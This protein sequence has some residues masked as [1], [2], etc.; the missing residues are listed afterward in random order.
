MSSKFVQAT[1]WRLAAFIACVIFAHAV[2]A[3]SQNA[4]ALQAKA[5]TPNIVMLLS[6]DLGWKDIGCYDGPVR[7]P[8]LDRL[9][10]GGMRF[11]DFYSGAAVC[12]PSRAVMLTGRTNVR[13]SIYSW[14]N[15]HDQRSHL[16][17]SEVTLAELLKSA[18]Y[19][20]GHFGKWHL[21]M[22]SRNFPN[23]P[24]PSDHG[25]DYWFAT[26]NNAQPSHRNP[27]NFVRNG[28]NVGPQEGYSC[29]L[30]VDEA[31]DWLD[32]QA[33]VDKPFFL[34]VW[35]HEPHAPLAA[36]AD[37]VE[38]YGDRMDP[39]A[40]YS[41][42]IAN[43]DQ[44]IKRLIAKLHEID[45]PENTLI[46][47]ASDNGSYRSDR[48]G[49]LRA[50]KGSNYEGGIR[51]PG[52]FYWPKHISP[53]VVSR[54]PAGL[55]DIVPTVC[56]IAGIRSPAAHLDGSDLSKLLTGTS[57]RVSREQPLFWCL[58]LSGPAIAMRDGRYSMV[59]F[60]NAAVPK[61]Q[62]GIRNIKKQIEETLKAKGIYEKETRGSTFAKQLFEGFSDRDAERLRGKF[63]RLNQ[64]HESWIPSLKNSNFIRF[65]LY[66][67]VA[68]PSQTRELSSQQPQVH[69]RL[70]AELTRIAK[71]VFN[72]AFDWS[73]DAPAPKQQS[74]SSGTRVHRLKETYRSPFDAFL[75]INR[76]PST[77]EQD[78]THDDLA[79]RILG[80]LANQE[81]RV[82]VKLPPGMNHQAYEGFK[83]ALE[84]GEERHAGNCFTC[85]HL[86][87]F[88][89]PKK[90]AIPSLRHY[91]RS[92][93]ELSATL[94]HEAH[95]NIRLDA[96]DISHLHAL[97]Q[98]LD[99]VSDKK[100][101][102][103]ILKSKV[104]DTSGAPK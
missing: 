102:E 60:R 24:T 72:E 101:R 66:D 75:Y 37:S 62:E 86:P 1:L 92:N 3:Q 5:A 32:A 90:K 78:E 65:E 49:Y 23:K 67:L 57:N 10:N 87:H 28:K 30:V 85:H 53:G 79:G 83:V 48:V 59:A 64:F 2:Q 71:D 84:G 40:V 21:G 41:G 100:F 68:D 22:P 7:T 4:N 103:L 36:P 27:R 69:A 51:V 29:D 50:T 47:Y 95:R 19:V 94:A 77:P 17:T 16:P 104:L 73:S 12:S 80:R 56:G 74:S 63:I 44:A 33:T 42:T 81:G 25:F 15:D 9:A 98:T 18:G 93:K 31:R 35:L 91:S 34:N 82:L 45:A 97:L 14:I 43:T 55:V 39:G 6:D 38:Q 61:D 46:I 8:T 26:A 54:E 70:K 58:P 11:T 96:K 99:E 89:Q 13:C 20:T 88:G 52:I 76:I